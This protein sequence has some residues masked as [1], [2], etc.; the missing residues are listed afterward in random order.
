M[1]SLSTR[2]C[3][4]L[5]TSFGKAKQGQS[6]PGTGGEMAASGP[7]VRGA[8]AVDQGNRE[9]TEGGQNLGSIAGAQAGAIFSEGHIAHIMRTV[10]NGPMST[11]ELQQPLRA[12][13]G[14][15]EGSDEIDDFGGGFVGFGHGAG[16]LS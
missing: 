16:Q 1:Q 2:A 8:E 10:F 4:L 5:L 11:I 3:E 14:G 9:I 15:R 7:N 6:L 12:S 13:F